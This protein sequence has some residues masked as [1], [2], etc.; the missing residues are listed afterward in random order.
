M[1]QLLSNNHPQSNRSEGGFTQQYTVCECTGNSLLARFIICVFACLLLITNQLSFAAVVGDTIGSDAEV[2]FQSNGLSFSK[3]DG[4]EFILESADPASVGNVK[5]DSSIDIWAPYDSSG[6]TTPAGSQLFTTETSQCQGTA[7]TTTNT[8]IKYANGTAIPL[9]AALS[10][11][12]TTTFKAG[13]PLIIRV[14]DL[15]QDVNPTIRDQI[16][17]TLTAAA[18]SSDSEVLLLT[19]TTNNSGEFVG[20]IQT[21]SNLNNTAP[22]NCLLA[23]GSASTLKVA[24]QDNNDGSDSAD[25]LV[26]FDPISRIFESLS[27]TLL[28]G[29]EITL[30][31]NDTGLPATVYGDDT[32]SSFPSTILSGSSVADASG[33][34]YKFPAG[35]YRF[36]YIPSGSY[37]IQVTNT[38]TTEFPSTISDEDIQALPAA[39]FLISGISRGES[40]TVSNQVF[41]AD[42]PLDSKSDRILL[43]KT[44][45]KDEAGVGDFVSFKI[46]VNNAESMATNVQIVDTLP[47]GLRYVK[48]SLIVAGLDAVPA[49]IS[50]DGR[51]ITINLPDME[52][53]ERL[54]LEYVTQ[55]SASAKGL[56]TNQAVA[57]HDELKSNVAKA[58]IQIKDDLFREK[59]HLFGRVILDDCQGNL[60]LDKDGVSGVRLYMEDGSY[61]VTD[62]QGEWH[63]EGIKPGTH[64][65][66]LDITTIPEYLEVSECA[67]SF[68]HAGQSYS[69]FVDVQPGSLWRADFRLQIKKPTIGEITQSIKN[70]LRPLPILTE[71]NTNAQTAEIQSS[72]V[73]E[74]IHYEITLEG[75]GIA[76][77]DVQELITLPAGVIYQTGSL[78][79]DG[80][81][82]T[83][84]VTDTKESL[85]LALGDKP[86]TWK[87]RIEFN[88]LVTSK[89]VKG[90]LTAKAQLYYTSSLKPKN[91]TS[92][93]PQSVLYTE[94]S[95]E[96]FLPPADG[97]A[98]PETAPRF[99]NFS[100]IL[101]ET[102]KLN[103]QDAI[104]K[105][106]G[107]KN[108]L[109]SVN[110]HT[111]NVPISRRNRHVYADNQVL[112]V[113]RAYAVASYL[114]EQLNLPA[115]NIQVN[116]FGSTKPIASNRTREG[117]AKNR[118]VEIRVLNADADIELSIQDAVVETVKL[119]NL[120]GN[121][122]ASVPQSSSL[123]LN[124]KNTK[125]PS[126]VKATDQDE[127]IELSAEP[128]QPEINES[129]FQDKSIETNWV[130]PTADFN[131]TISAT[132]IIIQHPQNTRIRLTLNGV[133]VHGV[134]FEGMTRSK[135]RPIAV[136]QWH[137]VEIQD[138]KNQ[139]V[140][141]VLN[142]DEEVIGFVDHIVHFAGAPANIEF[143]PELSY[144]YAD[145]IKPA[146]VAVKFTDKDGYPVRPHSTGSVNVSAP[147]QLL[148][149]NEYDFNPLI[150]QNKSL[151][152]V[153]ENGI[154][155]IEL[156]PSSQSGEV[157]L[158]FEHSNG[159]NDDIAVWLKPA[160]RDW[161]L[162]G[163]GDLTVGLNNAT[164][165]SSKL[166]NGNIDEN[167]YHDGRVAFF[168]KGQIPGDF[169]LTAAYDSA[170]EQTTPFATLLQ[171]GEYYTLYADA[172][173]Q[174][175]DAS[176]GEKLY[177]KVE[178][179]RFYA[180][181]GDLSTSL[182]KTQLGQYVRNL[183]GVQV[184]YFGDLFELTAFASESD[185]GFARDEIQGNGTSGLYK[186]SN[187]FIVPNSDKIIIETRDR[188]QSE[189]IIKRKELTRHLDYSLDEQSG[190]LYF[191]SPIANTDNNFNP[192]YI[193]AN[194]ETEQPGS[195]HVIGGR[196]GI[197]L[198]DDKV[199]AGITAVEESSPALDSQLTAVDA[200]VNLG[201]W[202]L[203]A[204]LAQTQRSTT[205]DI[206]SEKSSNA[207]RA[208]AVYRSG[209]VEV[210]GYAQR[211]E[212]EF[213]L[214]QQNTSEIDQQKIGVETSFYVSESDQI[215]LDTFHQ[216]TLSTGFERKQAEAD[217]THKLTN[218]SSLT[219]GARTAVEESSTGP[220]F[221][222]ELSLGANWAVLSQ[223]LRLN[224]KA[225]TDVSARSEDNDRLR[226]GADYRWTDSLSTFADYER[227][228]NDNNLERTTIGL[229]T[230]PWQGGQ[231]EQS[232]AQ[233]QQD[234][235][236]RLYSVSGLS[237]DWQVDDHWLVSF[238]FNQSRN[239][240]EQF[241]TETQSST[242]DFNAVS[243]GWAYRAENIQWTNRAERRNAKKS[244]TTLLHSSLYRPLTDSL[245]TGGSFNYYLKD[246]EQAENKNWDLTF[247]LALRPRKQN[248]AMLWQT[249]L[250]QENQSNSESNNETR[251]FINNIHANWM[252]STYDQLAM[253]YGFKRVLDQYNSDDY[254][255]TTNYLG[256]EWRHHLTQKWD[257]GAHG[258]ELFADGLSET[259]SYGLSVGY[260]PVK[261]LW[262]SIGYNFE[263]FVD[264]DFSA[265]NYTAQGVYLKMRFK[266]DQDTLASLRQ[267]FSW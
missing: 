20:L 166:S 250:V 31:D 71:Q 104:K 32:T 214:K 247:D 260:T 110:G 158:S 17:V 148:Q 103:L 24:Y 165:N 234:D 176:S 244:Q 35:G 237:H 255:S 224:A 186:L 50:N 66:Q 139:F 13:N 187:K 196:S 253:Q 208:E 161:L 218:I 55:V 162:V 230:Q 190:T 226:L 144:T 22:N 114:S 19:E 45:G 73:D 67:D 3:F 259:N 221:T 266:A 155:F 215:R 33:K 242:E 220:R 225:T 152:R 84:K 180:L 228:F 46:A 181:F 137:G 112:S 41:D 8:D 56:I 109:V 189:V 12:N 192:I 204:E 205:T 40:F 105:L 96:L 100:D 94:T 62:N 138:G 70:T 258:R 246:E 202:T 38:A 16:T 82:P 21:T 11:F 129:W 26:K 36:P 257:I 86:E 95:A 267:A 2:R 206:Y 212:D 239:L 261:N 195:G 63:L 222:D 193:V 199:K 87:Q 177:V 203:K 27:G 72:P 185:L 188:F 160:E 92:N 179:E 107:L 43:D 91:A 173:Q 131:P 184:A 124:D 163:L 28:N 49:S 42:I 44:A 265:A 34:I 77:T 119:G 80:L 172:S 115:K 30:I 125:S 79:I 53:N 216:E 254:A 182:N 223:K 99:A 211:I 197:K 198:L 217:W 132:N 145:G 245:A 174:G 171:P 170:K 151:Y 233:E 153:E 113:A 89:A 29:I 231:V 178:K 102:D 1:T 256:A 213:G 130:W 81:Q 210:N 23:L 157:R 133:P 159:V 248:I 83:V 68:F 60:N 127:R 169:L 7:G 122:D 241:P 106:H 118:R 93:N 209:D 167:I 147:Y 219:A 58:S 64:V 111:D 183:T 240:D 264:N 52:A 154:A 47:I 37:S 14:V 69:Q 121:I 4:A 101:T 262:A 149:A 232:I 57:V 98:D 136:S 128:T 243:T 207:Q 97:K 191:K 39:P 238:G 263:G 251:K 15:D 249:R 135:S 54:S 51:T 156:Q 117:R 236:Y 120:I 25:L 6:S 126:T 61:V 74:L 229:R 140:A 200:E 123:E 146:V 85:L 194:Y 142:R 88:G 252:F 5:T 141:E 78:L 9:P 175:N 90:T 235:G 134:Y 201:N 18:P 168:A 116:G 75:D 108:L 150:Q 59:A 227:S 164:N 10:A 48:N 76:V 65:V 143:L